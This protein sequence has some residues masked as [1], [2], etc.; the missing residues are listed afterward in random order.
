VN[1]DEIR[2]LEERAQRLAQDK[3]HLQLVVRLISRLTAGSGV[4]VTI[5]GLLQNVIDVIGGT[6]IVFYHDVGGTVRSVDVYGARLEYPDGVEPLVQQVFETRFPVE[7]EHDFSNTLLTTPAFTSAYTWVYPLLAGPELV[8]VLKMDSLHIGMRDL[9]AHLPAF[10]NYAAH[11]LKGEI[12]NYALLR[13]AFERLNAAND[14]LEEE[15]TIRRRSEAALREVRDGLESTVAERTQ[16]LETTNGQLQHE[17]T[18]RQRAEDALRRR[19]SEL[20]TVNRLLGAA[21][22]EMDEA[23][24]LALAGDEL[25]RLLGLPLW[26]AWLRDEFGDPV[27]LVAESH[28]ENAQALPDDE[29]AVRDLVVRRLVSRAIALS[30]PSVSADALAQE[31]SSRLFGGVA[32]SLVALPLAVGSID[33]GCL[34]LAASVERNLL[35]ADVGYAGAVASQVA[36]GL[37]SLRARAAARRMLQASEQSPDSIVITDPAGRI[38]YVNQTFIALTGYAKADV[39]GKNPNVLKSGRHDAEFYRQMWQTIMSGQ[40][41][42]GRLINRK[43]SGELF[44]EDAILAPIRDSQARITNYIAVKRDITGQVEQEDRLRQAQRQE[45]MPPGTSG[46]ASLAADAAKTSG[47]ATQPPAAQ[48]PATV[49]LV[50]DEEAIRSLIEQSLKRQGYKILVA[51]DGVHA[52][53]IWAH[54]HGQIDLLLSDVVMPRG[55]SGIDLF[56]YLRQ[57]KP[58]LKVILMSGYPAEIAGTNQTLG[59]DV[60]HLAKPFSLVGLA[61]IIKDLL[62][63][64]TPEPGAGILR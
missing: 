15:N 35:S 54:E 31:V 17:L 55:T 21:A 3:S 51:V 53:E 60:T 14:A 10:F 20:G 6:N 38:V 4:D 58:D 33:L 52:K 50:E 5:E 62:E 29:V 47:P 48:R 30:A 40:T 63:G 39:V 1:A 46:Q 26:Q 36:F 2:A 56:R 8:G 12:Q 25:A 59:D 42:H 43:K 24:M 27:R 16:E 57:V 28:P 44:A 45:G 18:E 61:T 34:V 11:V 19:N 41:W 7:H 49:L 23:E 13:E 64:R 32:Q 22:A 37:V 9:H